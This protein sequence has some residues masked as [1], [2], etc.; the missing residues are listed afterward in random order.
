M[1]EKFQSGSISLRTY[2]VMYHEA[3]LANFLEVILYHRHL[4]EQLAGGLA[5]EILDYC[6]RKVAELNSR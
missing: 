1:T 4:C 6:V 3:T 5:L 2:F